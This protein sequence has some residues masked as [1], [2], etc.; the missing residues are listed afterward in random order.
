MKKGW[1]H[2][3]AFSPKV[4][5]DNDKAPILHAGVLP[6]TTPSI[7]R[8]IYQTWKSHDMPTRMATAVAALRAANPSFEYRLFD[9]DECRAFLVENFLPAVVEAYDTLVPTAFKADLW[10][11]CV[12]YLRG[13]FYVDIKFIPVCG[14]SFETLLYKQ[15]WVLDNKWTFPN[16]SHGIYNAFMM[17]APGNPILLSVIRQLVKNVQRRI[18]G[19]KSLDITGPGLLG[20]LIPRDA[21]N[22]YWDRRRI[23]HMETHEPIL[24]EYDGYRDD[25]KGA[26]GVHYSELWPA[27][28]YKMISN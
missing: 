16:A 14:A 8:V 19:E 1:W 21:C 17:S 10:R 3:P 12:L 4:N 23:V 6:E 9:D 18:V 27:S 20:G 2:V 15:Y 25:C 13:G 26:G 24:I 7:P 5:T 22:L 28:V 11:Y